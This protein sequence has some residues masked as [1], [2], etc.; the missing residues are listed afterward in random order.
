MRCWSTSDYRLPPFVDAHRIGG[1][2]FAVQAGGLLYN[3][4]QWVPTLP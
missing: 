2:T 1:A 3:R 4:E